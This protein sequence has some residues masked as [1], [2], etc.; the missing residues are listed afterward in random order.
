[1]VA[2]GVGAIGTPSPRAVAPIGFVMSDCTAH[3]G[4]KETVMSNEVP[5]DAADHRSLYAPGFRWTG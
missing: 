3:A 4:S 2:A 1:M 5:G